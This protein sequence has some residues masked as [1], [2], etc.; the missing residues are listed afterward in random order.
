M[1]SQTQVPPLR[2]VARWG[3]MALPLAI[4]PWAVFLLLF[5]LRPG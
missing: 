4:V 1:S 2:T 5:I 3:K